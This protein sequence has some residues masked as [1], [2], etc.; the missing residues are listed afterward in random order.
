M[1]ILIFVF[2]RFNQ[3]MSWFREKIFGMLVLLGS[4]LPVSDMLA[5]ADE[6]AT[7]NRIKVDYRLVRKWGVAGYVEYR[8]MDNLKQSD[9][10]GASLMLNCKPL[11]WLNIEGGY[12][13]HYRQKGGDWSFRHRYKL[14]AQGNIVRGNWKFSLRERFQRTTSG[15]VAGN[16]LR[17]RLRS[18]Y[19]LKQWMNPYFSIELFQP[20]GGNAFFT[21]QR[22]RY[23]PG[24]IWRFSESYSIDMFYCRQYETKRCQNIFG[25][26]LGMKF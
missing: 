12:E 5:Q 26:E 8:S 1:N 19:V 14:S 18:S 13:L 20:L 24:I 16:D 7:W 4:A 21:V 10:W 22:L 15:G 25:V 6:F 3:S 23:R 9:R 17:S 11:S 2:Q